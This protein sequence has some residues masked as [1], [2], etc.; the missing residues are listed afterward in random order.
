MDITQYI[1]R[2]C[3]ALSEDAVRNFT[4]KDSKPLVSKPEELLPQFHVIPD[5]GHVIK[6]A[7]A[8]LIVQRVSKEY[9]GK[10]WIKMDDDMWLKAHYMLL[11]GSEGQSSKW[12]R[13]AGFDEAWKDVPKL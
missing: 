13:A 8:L 6:M 10:D 3:P 7:R 4:P 12:V 5:D 11:L 9:E 1:A 2:G